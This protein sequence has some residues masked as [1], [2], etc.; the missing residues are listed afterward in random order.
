MLGHLSQEN[1]HPSLVQD[2]FSKNSVNTKISVA[3]RQ[4]PSEIIMVSEIG[5][6]KAAPNSMMQLDLFD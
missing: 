3:S 1:N 2:L 5:N 6:K 4:Q